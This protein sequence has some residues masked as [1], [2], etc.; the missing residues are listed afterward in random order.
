MSDLHVVLTHLFQ[1]EY[2]WLAQFFSLVVLPFAHEDLAITLGAYFLVN[3]L[4]PSALVVLGIYAGMVASDFLLY[5]IGAAA[6]YSPWLSRLTVN[7]GVR[8]FGEHLKRNLFGVVALCR[9]V[10][11]VVFVAFIACGWTR[12]SL[13]HFA[14]ASFLVSALYLPLMLCIVVF[15]GAALDG[16]VGLWAWPVLLGML[17]AIG[18]VRHR[19]FSF[20]GHGGASAVGE[21]SGSPRCGSREFHKSSCYEPVAVGFWYMRLVFRWL[22]FAAR[23]R[24]LTLPALANPG[25]KQ[26]ILDE[27]RSHY[28][29][30]A[31]SAA[32]ARVAD[33]VVLAPSNFAHCLYLDLERAR[34]MLTHAA[35][36]FPLMV[37][38][39]RAQW[40]A[41]RVDDM[42]EL[43]DLLRD[44]PAGERL[45]L[46]RFVPKDGRATVLYARLPGA[47]LGRIL[48]LTFRERGQSGAEGSPEYRDGRRQITPEL[49][50][51]FHE[52][53]CA[54]REFH[55]GRFE[56]RF[57]SLV[58]LSRAQDFLI[59]DVNGVGGEINE[60]RD[61]AL[62]RAEV[63]QR[64]LEQ[65][66]I[67]FLIGAKNRAR[68]FKPVTLREVL[69]AF[70][71]RNHLSRRHAVWG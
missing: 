45:I 22:G 40:S 53:A 20:R 55:Y 71:R 58:E 12:V 61:P 10:P 9:V 54:M 57:G 44:L 47:R 18:F 23:H 68:G 46:Q 21:S 3:K 70:L 19:V 15:F 32:P 50:R 59:V 31:R 43:R 26:C 52:I 2:L 4:M 13:A 33:F 1:H 35:L 63:Y 66:R 25:D 5:G 64:M 41:R 29:E 14:L 8:A 51:A 27:L 49:E 56:L 6:R 42:S 30:A 17:A 69:K 11:G 48:S 37:K 24:S 38:T 36:S 65:Q 34:E 39:D 16:H 7:D 28:L 62:S 67:M 60:R